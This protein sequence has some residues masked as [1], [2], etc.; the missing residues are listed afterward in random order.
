MAGS[1]AGDPTGFGGGTVAGALVGGLAAYTLGYGYKKIKSNDGITRLQWHEKFLLDEWQACALR[2]LMIA[3]VGRCQGRWQEPIPAAW[4]AKWQ[5]LIADWTHERNREISSALTNGDV[6]A[7]RPL[8][9]ALLHDSRQ[10]AL[11]GSGLK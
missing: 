10:P 3:H 5:K 8:M 6:T 11:S 9:S 2:Y 4:P 1:R 7:I